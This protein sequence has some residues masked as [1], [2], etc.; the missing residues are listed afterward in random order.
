MTSARE[1]FVLAIA[2]QGDE[3]PASTAKTREEAMARA[4]SYAGGVGAY[5]QSSLIAVLGCER[6]LIGS[7]AAWEGMLF[8]ARDLQ[9]RFASWTEFANDY[10]DQLDVLSDG[11]AN[12]N[13][14]WWL[15]DP[16]SPWQRIAWDTDLGEPEPILRT[17]CARCGNVRI[18]PW[19][20]AYIYCDH[21]AEL[22][23]FDAAFTR[24][25]AAGPEYVAL[26]AEL[27]PVIQAALADHDVDGMRVAQRRLF[28]AWLDSCP[29]AVSI[30]VHRPDYRARFV[31]YLAE[32]ETVAAFDAD[33]T[34]LRGD[35]EVA[36]RQLTLAS[37]RVASKPFWTM[38]DAAFA[39]ADRRDELARTHGIYDKHP[40]GA[41]RELQ[42]RVGWSMFA[43]AWVPFLDDGERETLLARCKL[44]PERTAVMAPWP[45]TWMTCG[46]CTAHVMASRGATWMICDDCGD[47]IDVG[48]CSVCPSC[49]TPL[50]RGR[51]TGICPI[52]K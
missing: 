15:N 19:V 14:S 10:I 48:S 17:T 21:C 51:D 33:A 35:M 8:L 16:A 4:K 32:A 37:D 47:R 40:D 25:A 42:Q 18:R 28:D 50:A 27:A 46:T 26:V 13:L 22:V 34:R 49:H 24:T 1:R 38:V 45:I 11:R 29:L 23:D 31:D 7:T 20:T 6:R 39:H 12:T 44:A 52:C 43:Q 3:F 5:S 30:R 36:M 2:M 9:H 41:S